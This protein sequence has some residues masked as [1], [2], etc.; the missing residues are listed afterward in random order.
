[1]AKRHG[2]PGQA[3][4]RLKVRLKPE[5]VTLGLAG[6]DPTTSV[7]TYVEPAAWNDLIADPGTLLIDTRNA[8]EVAVGSFEGAVD[9]G[10]NSFRDFPAWVEGVLV[11]LVAE[12]RPR[13]LAL[14][15]P[16]GIRCEQAPSSLLQRGF[17]G[18]HH[19]RGGILGYLAEVEPHQSRWRGDCFVFDQRVALNHQLQPGE[20]S[21]CH[22]CRMPLSPPD[23]ALPSYQEGV[24]CRHCADR[25]GAADRG[26]LL[27][28]Q[29]QMELAR[30]RGD[31]HLGRVF[32][33]AASPSLG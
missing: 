22:G 10:T 25:L 27:E 15:C 18:V 21:L 5:I 13:A 30:H 9:P 12:H 19:L 11:P 4:H 6:V 1:V 24:C 2:S 17:D 28:R 20:H 7:G 16:G 8:Y 26:R 14:Y 3:F 33:Q 31:V 29:R 32:P 23:R